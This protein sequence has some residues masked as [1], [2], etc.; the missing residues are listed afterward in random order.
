MF[1][2][3]IEDIQRKITLV[4]GRHQLRFS[5]WGN[6]VP[7]SFLYHYD[8]H[9]FSESFLAAPESDYQPAEIILI[10]GQLNKVQLLKLKN[11]YDNLE[12]GK[13]FIVQIK[14]SINNL[15]EKDSYM[16]VD[17]LDTVI[18]ID[19]VYDRYPFHLDDLL[20]QIVELK[21]GIHAG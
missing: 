15:I 20:K 2:S 9:D 7:D 8:F 4:T 12:E 11:K 3:V 13:K 21:D 16:S 6:D 10:V 5:F 1:G 18:P 17:A 19:L 14:G